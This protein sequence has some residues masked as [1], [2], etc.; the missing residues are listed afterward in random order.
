MTCRKTGSNSWSSCFVFGSKRFDSGKHYWEV[1]CDVLSGGGAGTYLGV[2]KDPN[3]SYYSSDMCAGLN[4]Y[5]YN[6]YGG[7]GIRAVRGDRI[8]VLCDF[9]SKKIYFFHNSRFTGITGIVINN[10]NINYKNR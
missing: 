2:T 5:N 9:T 7:S 8:G 1:I 10:N 3:T 6:C 4:G